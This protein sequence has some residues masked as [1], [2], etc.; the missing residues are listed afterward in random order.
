MKHRTLHEAIQAYGPIDF[1]TGVWQQRD[2]WLQTLPIPEGMFPNWHVLNTKMPVRHILVN[3][4]MYH[5][6]WAALCAV[7]TKGFADV[8]KTFDGCF[9]IR[10]VRG[11]NSAPSAHSYGL[12]IDINAEENPMGSELKTE[13]SLDFVKCFTIQGFDWGGDFK[14]RKDP[15]HFSY[16]WE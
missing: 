1:S 5:P 8:L 13:F 3:R 2:T 11:S 16:C 12:A 4:D 10:L 15:M 6:L 9:N 14:T 7:K